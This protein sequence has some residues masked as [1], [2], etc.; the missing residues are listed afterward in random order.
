MSSTSI[1]APEPTG[2]PTASANIPAA[3][4]A[5]KSRARTVVGRGHS[6]HTTAAAPP[7]A[8][9]PAHAGSASATAALGHD[10]NHPAAAA[11]KPP[12]APAVS[13]TTLPSGPHSA[14]AASPA[15]PITSAA[16]TAGPTTRLATGETSDNVPN[17]PT[18]SGTVLTVAASVRATGATIDVN[19]FGRAAASH[20]SASRAK[21][22]IPATAA[23]D[24][25]KPRSNALAGS[26]SNVAAA[27]TLSADPPSV[28]RPLNQAAETASAITHARTADGWTPE[29]TT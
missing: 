17:V 28:R 18:I 26:S 23:T 9:A 6:A 13:S 11:E 16:E 22:T 4:P 2:G 5:S 10:A 14:A 25:W 27:A 1:R 29:S 15:R 7:H 8:S 12:T 24:S 20:S 3:S 19:H 21:N